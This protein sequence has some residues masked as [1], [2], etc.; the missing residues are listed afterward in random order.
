MKDPHAIRRVVGLVFDGLQ[1][2][3]PATEVIAQLVAAGVPPDEAPELYATVKESIQ[4]GALSDFT[5]GQTAPDGPPDDPLQAEAF[6]EGQ[7]AFREPDLWDW[8]KWFNVTVVLLL[9]VVLFLG[10]WLGWWGG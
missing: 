3:S 10:W 9:L 2:N 5:E 6:R 7:A 1:R 8:L 4:E